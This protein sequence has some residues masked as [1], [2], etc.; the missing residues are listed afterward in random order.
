MPSP[1]T[2]GNT[3]GSPPSR[4]E[5]LALTRSFEAARGL[6]LY[7]FIQ[8]AT[9]IAPRS[10]PDFYMP[11][12]KPETP[13]ADAPPSID[14]L[15]ERIHFDAREGRIWLDDQRMLL[16][17]VSA[18]GVL[19][20]ELIETLGTERA[21]GLITRVGYNSGSHDAE[22]ARKLR[23]AQ[24]ATDAMFVGP[25][26]HML[27]GVARVESVRMEIDEE[28]GHFDG[29]FHWHGSAEAEEHVRLYGIGTDVACWQQV[30]Y[31]SGF[32]SRFLGR[33]VMF[34][35][36]QCRAQG[37]PHCVIVGR[38]VEDW[39][40]DDAADDLRSLQ[41]DTLS[42]GPSAGP[43]PA[44][45]DATALLDD[46]DVVGVSAGFN[47]VCHMVR[48]AARTRATVLFQGESGVGKEVLAK[49]LHRIGPRAAGP[50][51]AINCAAIPAELVEAELF[52][53]EKGAYT[54]AVATR[55]GRFERADGGTLF[56]DEVGILSW[57]AQGKLLRALQEREVERVGGTASRKVDVRVVAAS[58][59][60][61]REEVRAGRFRE[62]LFFR[63]NVL[64]VRVPPLRERRE[65]I[66]VFLNHF[67][68]KFNR[69]DERDVTGFTGRAIDALL[70]YDWPGNIRE[71]ENLV[72]RGVVLAP[73]GGAIDTVHLFSGGERVEGGLLALSREGSLRAG[74]AAGDR[75]AEATADDGA[76]G[77][78]PATAVEP[79]PAELARRVAALLTGS[80]EGDGDAAEAVHAPL[81]A[82]EAALIRSAMAR[83]QGNQ[84]AAARLLGLTRAQL[85]YRLKQLGAAAA[86]TSAAP[87]T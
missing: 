58:N 62:D 57:P 76:S 85:I 19:R 15:V 70:A 2:P 56:L 25:Q 46:E 74:P 73:D 44:G 3:L 1:P 9:S 66:P 12:P 43:R 49:A 51:V 31:A 39:G 45:G 68:H 81:D 40:A 53:V 28:H 16:V 11:L 17:H 4:P 63:L 23:G 21:R 42:R 60:D 6:A 10:C 55:P 22:L 59:L 75:A 47:A 86:A 54:G 7:Q 41:A 37:A 87:D 18:Q 67:L 29:E 64:P 61:L 71:L 65:D 38:P 77:R 83:T 8:A 84:S 79:G 78:S 34:R 50:F 52:G 26:L 32:V 48:R 5:N 24:R 33:P 36:V 80:A 35:E 72:E 20:Q 69:R 27:E 14:D 13:G 30:G 82:I